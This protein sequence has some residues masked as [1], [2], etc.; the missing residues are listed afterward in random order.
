[1]MGK[2]VDQRPGAVELR[3][4]PSSE[5]SPVVELV[6]CRNPN[7]GCG[8][9]LICARSIDSMFAMLEILAETARCIVFAWAKIT[10]PRARAVEKCQRTHRITTLRMRVQCVRGSLERGAL[11]ATSP[12][13]RR[14]ISGEQMKQDSI[15]PYECALVVDVEPLCLVDLVRASHV[16]DHCAPRSR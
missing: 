1:M 2:A 14:Q 10:K 4:P 3:F 12:S 7:F 5:F 9:L 6:P 15:L 8:S 16:P 13:E 11:F